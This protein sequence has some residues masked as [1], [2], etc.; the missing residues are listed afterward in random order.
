MGHS[1][2][3]QYFRDNLN[4]NQ[5]WE[6]RTKL[7]SGILFVFGVISLGNLWI[8]F[9]ALVFAMGFAVL[10]GLTPMQLFKKLSVLIPFLALMSIPLIFGTGIPPAFDRIELAAQIIMKAFAAMTFTLFV[11]INQPVEEMLEA[12]EHLKGPAAVTTVIYLTYRYG[13]L[14][15]QEIQTTMRALRSRLFNARLSKHSLAIYGELSGGLLLKALN[16]SEIVYRAMVSRGF[17][18][19]IPIGSPRQ[20]EAVD[21]LKAGVPVIFLSILIFI[22]K[23]VL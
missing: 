23:V 11:F 17:C 13:F 10:N 14:F 5:P 8:L 21:V 20:I 16:R 18:G 1:H 2:H 3:H 6:P 12:M 15:I 22:E 7:I 19:S 9:T 4:F